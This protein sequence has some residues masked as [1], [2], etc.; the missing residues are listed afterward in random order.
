M[1]D[2]TAPLAEIVEAYKVGKVEAHEGGKEGLLKGLEEINRIV[3]LDS[4]RNQWK[5][6]NT[7]F[8][9]EYLS[10]LMREKY[11]M[12][13]RSI[14]DLERTVK[15]KYKGG[16][17]EEITIPTFAYADIYSE[18]WEWCGPQNMVVISAKLPIMP[19][20]IRKKA[21]GARADLFRVYT[22]ALETPIVGDYLLTREMDDAIFWV[23]EDIHILWKPKMEDFEVSLRGIVKPDPDPALILDFDQKMYLIDTWDIEGEEPF[24]HYL[25]EFKI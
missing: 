23:T 20:D 6:A 11:P 18:Y 3:P 9:K 4:E 25:R 17:Q 10:C 16:E 13:D 7:F 2:S 1:V 22:E 8:V 12:L 19:T 15:V 5:E 14:L 21:R 24:E